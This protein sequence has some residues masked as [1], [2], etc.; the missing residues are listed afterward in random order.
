[1]T[2]NFE[3]LFK[4]NLW[5]NLRLLDFCATLSNER[6]SIAATGAFGPPRETLL[7]IVANEYGYLDALGVVFDDRLTHGSPA[8]P[9]DALREHMR[10]S[11]EA[12]LRRAGNTP[13]GE[14][15]RV[16]FQGNEFDMPAIIP[17][18][19][20][21]NHGTEHRGQITLS[22]TQ[23]GVEPPRLD[24]WTYHEENQSQARTRAGG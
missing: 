4:H 19:Q 9:F 21:I 5:A 8:P 14:V 17:L 24:A 11:G 12:T 1:M 20:T 16:T 3:E 22:L 15:R 10:R 13:E 6:L 2:S 7:H 23:A 18:L